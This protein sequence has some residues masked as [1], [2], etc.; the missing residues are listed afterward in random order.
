MTKLKNS[1]VT[2]STTYLDIVTFP[3]I[4]IENIFSLLLLVR[5]LLSITTL[6]SYPEIVVK[7]SFLQ[8]HLRKNSYQTWGTPGNL[9][10]FVLCHGSLHSAKNI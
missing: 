5:Y 8:L 4:A 3:L 7:I 10:N 1:I 9:S 6:N 2:T